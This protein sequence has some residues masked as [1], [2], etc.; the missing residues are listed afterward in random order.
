MAFIDDI[1]DIQVQRISATNPTEGFGIPFIIGNSLVTFPD[2]IKSYSSLEDVLVDF[3]VD[4]PEYKAAKAA[5]S[6]SSIVPTIKIAQQGEFDSYID[7]YNEAVAKDPAFYHVLV[8]SEDT[9]DW[10][11]ISGVVETQRK[12]MGVASDETGILTNTAL[13]LAEVYKD[14]NYSRTYGFY[15]G[16]ATTQFITSALSSKI[17][18]NQNTFPT[19]AY[20]ELSGVTTDNLTNIERSNISL[21][22][23]NYYTMLA[24]SGSTFDGRMVNGFYIDTQVGI[25]WM[26]SNL[27]LSLANLLKASESIP[28]TV[29]GYDLIR[30][31]INSVLKPAVDRRVINADYSIT[32]PPISSVPL[33][34][35]TARILNGIVIEATLTGAIHTMKIKM[36]LTD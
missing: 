3:T 14:L 22:N 2:I 29:G 27:E 9:V 7:A 28:Y 30:N 13:N 12:I 21:N 34:D 26:T 33:V 32:F 24:G 5:F 8:L 1:I 23:F 36:I 35:K 19:W 15:S 20:K 16:T 4:Q 10:I 31:A 6:Q 11:E 25:D 17:L 18:S